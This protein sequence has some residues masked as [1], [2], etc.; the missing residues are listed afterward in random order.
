MFRQITVLTILIILTG[1]GAQPDN[2]T[3][4]QIDHSAALAGEYDDCIVLT[5]GDRNFTGSQLTPVLELL[6]GDSL[7]VYTKV[8]ALINRMLILQDAHNRG[9]DLTREMGLYYYERQREKLQNDW[10]VLI[11]DQKVTLSPDTVEAY[12]SQMGTMLIY[13]AISVKE[14]ALCDSLR[15]LVHNG[16]NMGDLAEEYSIMPREATNR[17]VVGPVD[18]METMAWDYML[19]KDLETGELSPSDSTLA[20]WRF[21]RIDSTY[22][23]SVPPMEE[24][25]DVIGNRILGKLKMAYK[26]ELFDS[27]RTVNNFQM[28]DGI[29]ELIADHFPENSQDY[30]PFSREQEDMVAYTFTGGRRTLYSL[31]ENIRNLPSMGSNAPDDPQWIREYSELLGLYDIMAMEAMKL[32]LDTLPETVSYMDQRFGNQVLDSYYAQVI[33]PRLVPSE[34]K[35][36]EIYE[37]EQALLMIPEERVFKTIAAAGEEQLDLLEEVMASGG[38]PFMMTEELTNTQGILA[39]GESIITVPMSAGDIPPP[40]SEM[41]FSIELHESITCSISVEQVLL[42][43]LTEI[44]PEHKAT[45]G[46]SKD[47]LIEIFRLNEEEEVITGLVDSLHSVYHIDI[48]REYI[49]NFVYSDSSV[50]NQP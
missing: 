31:V 12:Y 41:L 6:D 33:D 4:E 15:L 44:I 22:Q 42:F 27:L 48:D 40:W 43:E 1:C 9:Y 47:Q 14:K 23:G 32:G 30:E 26:E 20:G 18:L 29:P 17:G 50:V 21:L 38:D 46:E 49:D 37:T 19:L 3:S 8:D 2:N 24:I 36:I 34:E 28:I 11:L 35:L 45:F 5:I 7:M 25:G 16:E 10:L 13:R 39:P